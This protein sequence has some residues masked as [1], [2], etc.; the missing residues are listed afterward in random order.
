MV[1][2]RT[3]ILWIR[4]LALLVPHWMHRAVVF[5]SRLVVN[6]FP[7][8]SEDCCLLPASYIYPPLNTS[9]WYLPPNADN[10]G[11]LS[12][13]CN[14]VMYKYEVRA[15]QRGSYANSPFGFKYLHGVYLVSE[16][17]DLLVRPRIAIPLRFLLKVPS[18]WTIWSEACQNVSISE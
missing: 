4:I 2:Y 7:V 10:L 5:V 1:S 13:D 17:P 9:E 11:D 8:V 3:R 12:C 15:L 6:I 14:T 16:G 18:R